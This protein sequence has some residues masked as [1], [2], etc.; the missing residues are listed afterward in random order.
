MNIMQFTQ[1]AMCP[2]AYANTPALDDGLE[3]LTRD[4]TTRNADHLDVQTLSCPTCGRLRFV[5]V[6]VEAAELPMAS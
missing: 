1:S 6:P 5:I 4:T 3:A 2:C